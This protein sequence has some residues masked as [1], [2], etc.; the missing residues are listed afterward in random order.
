MI[1]RRLFVCTL[2]S[3]KAI[4]CSPGVKLYSLQLVLRLQALN[5]DYTY[6]SQECIFCGTLIQCKCVHLYCFNI[7]AVWYSR[8]SQKGYFSALEIV[9]YVFLAD[10]IR[11]LIYK[12]PLWE[13]LW[14]RGFFN[15]TPPCSRSQLV[16]AGYVDMLSLTHTHAHSRYLRHRK[17]DSRKQLCTVYHSVEVCEL[18]HT[19]HRFLERGPKWHVMLC[20]ARVAYLAL[21]LHFIDMQ[22]KLKPEI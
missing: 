12:C 1:C 3:P 4:C 5:F 6:K 17:P 21:W 19:Q 2:K 10:C 11:P 8:N 7:Q 14:L 20:S 13:V 15:Q 22:N 9:G 18:G 16:Q